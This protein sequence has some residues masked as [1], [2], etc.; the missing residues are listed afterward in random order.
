MAKSI[1]ALPGMQWQV[2]LIEEVLEKGHR[3][4]VVN[5][6]SLAS[7][8]IKVD[9]TLASDVFDKEKVIEFCRTH[10]IEA[11]MSDDYDIVIYR[12]CP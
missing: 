12:Q 2:P 9:G 1:L 8:M 5:P 6:D 7:S 10:H 11:V 3:A 4:L